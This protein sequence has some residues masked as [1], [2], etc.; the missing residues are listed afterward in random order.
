MVAYASSDVA[1]RLSFTRLEVEFEER[2]KAG[3]IKEP[4][5]KGNHATPIETLKWQMKKKAIGEDKFDNE[6]D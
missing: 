2:L 4:V 5:Y 1:P 6:V 3:E